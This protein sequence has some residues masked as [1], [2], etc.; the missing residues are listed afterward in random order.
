MDANVRA[1]LENYEDGGIAG[2]EGF[3]KETLSKEALF[4]PPRFYLEMAK[5]YYLSGRADKADSLLQKLSSIP[6]QLQDGGPEAAEASAWKAE[7][8]RYA[9]YRTCCRDS[10]G[11]AMPVDQDQLQVL[12]LEALLD[13]ESQTHA[14]DVQL[15]LARRYE[16]LGVWQQV[17]MWYKKAA[18]QGFPGLLP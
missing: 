11:M 18:E 3:F 2:A 15:E 8:D 10:A 7:L 17:K 16:S 12:N 9:R 1:L 6:E 4:V 13:L 5:L 14:A